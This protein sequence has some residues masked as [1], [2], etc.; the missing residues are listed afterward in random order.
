MLYT[1]W[2]IAH[3]S[4]LRNMVC[5]LVRWTYKR[6]VTLRCHLEFAFYNLNHLVFLQGS[7]TW[8]INYYG[9]MSKTTK[10]HATRSD[11]SFKSGGRIRSWVRHV[12]L[13]EMPISVFLKVS[14]FT[15]TTAFLLTLKNS[16]FSFNLTNLCPA[17]DFW[18]LVQVKHS[19]CHGSFLYVTPPWVITC[20]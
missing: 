4:T 2:K 13:S 12:S 8:R 6:G 9:E 18:Q 10:L 17:S 19:R 14:I 20:H 16:E 11:C 5:L 7:F 1:S 3:R 15:K